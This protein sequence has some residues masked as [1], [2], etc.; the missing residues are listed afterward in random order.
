MPVSGCIVIVEQGLVLS[1]ISDKNRGGYG[2]PG[3]KARRDES[4]RQCAIR[5][6]R[7][8][9]GILVAKTSLLYRTECEGFDCSTFLAEEWS[10]FLQSSIEGVPRWVEPKM[11]LRGRYA[12]YNRGVLRELKRFGVV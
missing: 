2:L 3:G 8:E 6:C 11:L 4:P 12:E 1:H 9:T 5:E 7:E 10:G